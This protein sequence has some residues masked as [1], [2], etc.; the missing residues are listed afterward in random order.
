MPGEF[1]KV[2][3]D[4]DPN[5]TG[6][7]MDGSAGTQVLTATNKE[8]SAGGDGRRGRRPAA[9]TPS[10]RDS[11]G[12]LAANARALAMTAL[13]MR[14]W[15]SAE[16][17][18]AHPICCS[19]LRWWDR[20]FSPAN[21]DTRCSRSWSRYLPRQS[22]WLSP[23]GSRATDGWRLLRIAVAILVSTGAGV[24]SLLVY[25][26]G[27]VCRSGPSVWCSTSCGHRRSRCFCW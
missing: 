10:D 27:E 19:P 18:R 3:V 17:C 7:V 14:R 25:R 2:T 4:T 5:G 12:F 20:P 22:S 21:R 16:Y 13:I 15:P 26:L 24:Y 8:C 11:A 6:A 9:G 1:G 23:G